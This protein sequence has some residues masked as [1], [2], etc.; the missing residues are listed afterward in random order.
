MK[1]KN[2]LF[3]VIIPTYNRAKLLKKAIQS[4]IDQTISDWELVVVDDGSTDHTN[5]TV[6]GF[7]DERIHYVFQEKKERS[8][9]RNTGIEKAKGK[10]IC[11]LDDDDYFLENHLNQFHDFIT[12][13]DFP[14]IILRSGYYKEFENGKRTQTPNYKIQE[15]NNP[16]NFSAYNMCGVWSLC[17]PKSYLKEDDF[18]IDF[19]HWQD[20]H[21]ILR[22][23][24]KHPFHQIDAHTYV[25]RI[26]PQMGSISHFSKTEFSKRMELNLLAIQDLF[27]NHDLSD[28]VP[29][30]TGDFLLA[31]KQMQYAIR[32]IYILGRKK[33]LEL[34]YKSLTQKISWRLWKS[35]LI[36]PLGF[37]YPSYLTR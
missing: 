16:V 20:T 34:L 29:R 36:Y 9:A 21:L 6:L 1:R 11:F 27:D 5:E 19:P 8:V 3:T 17:I 25:Y 14:E 7:G 37:I 32:S 23:L 30:E 28:F 15:H 12:K 4:V 2:P 18:P 13:E 33:S 10:Y 31:E 22:L 35:Y 26:H 24:S